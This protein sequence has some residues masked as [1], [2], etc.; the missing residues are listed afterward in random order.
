VGP[1]FSASNKYAIIRLGLHNDNFDFIAELF[2]G[3]ATAKL[4]FDWGRGLSSYVEGEVRG[5]DNALG[6]AARLGVTYA[7][8]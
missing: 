8:H 6:V 5:R 2:F 1:P 7:F 4:N 3:Q